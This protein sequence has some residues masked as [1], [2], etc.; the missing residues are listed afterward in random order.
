MLC[1]VPVA[2]NARKEPIPTWQA[3][4]WKKRRFSLSWHVPRVEGERVLYP[5]DYCGLYN[6]L[7]FSQTGGYD[8]AITNPYW[9]KLDFGLRCFL[10]GERLHGTIRLGLTYTGAPPQEDATPDEG[11]KKVWL[12][13]LAVR[14]RRE[15]GVLPAWRA[16]GLHAALR[17]RAPVRAEGVPRCAALG[18][19][20]P[21]PGS[22]AVRVTSS[23]GG[24]GP[25]VATGIFVQ[26]R[27]GSTRLPAKALLPLP[28]RLHH[29]ARHAGPG[30]LSRRTCGRSS[31]IAKANEP[32]R[33]LHGR[34]ASRC[35]RGPEE[36]VLARYC[37]ASRAYGTDRI[38]R[39]TGDNPLT[40]AR[41][42]RGILAEH[43][44]ARADLSHYLDIP[45]GS[46]IE[47]VAARALYEAEKDADQKDE[48]EH[49]TTF[50]Y[51]HP[52]RF[53]ILEAPAPAHAD[54]PRGRVTVDTPADLREM[55]QLFQDLYD[56][57][58]DRDRPGH[59]VAEGAQSFPR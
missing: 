31:R 50:L 21:L 1:T 39:A 43:E 15:M 28:G 11:Y 41:L 42:A 26:V 38:I 6:R 10:W 29:P 36:D 12:K 18:A 22:A 47:V 17:H 40:S 58:A 48:R 34:R 8:P 23:T 57:A 53:R 32:S 9:Q 51:R 45:W 20:P 44:K 25:D 7:K 52:Q 14:T 5:F 37:M 59:C 4:L 13:N 46:G 27:L 16:L 54:M 33:P 35:S 55:T 56:R 3:P 30:S 24:S 49:I 19:D 2:R